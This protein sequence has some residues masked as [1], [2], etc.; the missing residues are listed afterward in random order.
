MAEIM[1]R[2]AQDWQSPL[3]IAQKR[4]SRRGQG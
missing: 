4:I 3:G 1:R 2:I